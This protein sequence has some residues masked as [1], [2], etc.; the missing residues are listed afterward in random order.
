[1]IYGADR[2]QAQAMRG[3]SGRRAS[4]GRLGIEAAFSE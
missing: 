3:P 1:M 2:D 4:A